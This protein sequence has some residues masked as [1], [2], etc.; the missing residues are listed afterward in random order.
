MFRAMAACGVALGGAAC[1]PLDLGTNVVWW[2]DAE[3]SDFSEWQAAPGGG[4]YTLTTGSIA[5]SSEHAR[6]GTH[7]AKLTASAAGADSGAGL[8]RSLPTSGEAYYSAWFFIPSPVTTETYWTIEQFR[9]RPLDD[10]TPVSGINVNLRSRADG[11]LV[12]YVLQN[13]SQYLAAPLAD[14]PPVVPVDRWFQI[15][16]LVRFARDASGRLALWLDGR[17][18]YDFGNRSTAGGEQLF[19]AVCNVTRI[20]SPAPLSVFVDDA[21]MTFERMTPAGVTSVSE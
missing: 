13:E 9:S 14:P 15:E 19:W 20:T 5:P 7:S 18:V 12:V 6:S 11:S 16:V 17:P 8:W 10:P 4:N 1:A 21:A 2:S 3:T